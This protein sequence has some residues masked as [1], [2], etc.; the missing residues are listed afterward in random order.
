MNHVRFVMLLCVLPLLSACAVYRPLQLEPVK[1]STPIA[2]QFSESYYYYDRDKDINIVLRSHSKDPATGKPVEQV[3]TIRAFWHPIGGITTLN[4]TAVNATFRYLIMTPDAVGLY[5][6]AGF[7]RLQSKTG[8]KKFEARVMDGD[9]TLMQA[10]ATFVDNIGRARI[11]G[12]VKAT[13]DDAKAMDLMLGA[14][15]EFFAR[16]LLS[17]PPKPPATA[18][19]PASTNPSTEPSS[20]PDSEPATAPANVP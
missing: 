13:Y 4:S 6:G 2:P 8:T 20:E 11:N 16:S 3:V 5:E 19:A 1:R 7:V 18:T 17:K 12:Y 15:R 14:Q 10:S 9:M